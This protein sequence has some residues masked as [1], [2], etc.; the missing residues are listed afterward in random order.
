M[1]ITRRAFLGAAGG[2]TFGAMA[3]GGRSNTVEVVDRAATLPGLRRPMR[4]LFFSDQHLP[5][6]FV[7]FRA[8]RHVAA[9]FRPHLVLVGGDTVDRA[10]NERLVDGFAEIEADLGK[11][12]ILGNW[13]YEGHCDLELLQR[14]YA[15]AGVRLLVNETALWSSREHGQMRLVGLDDSRRGR[16]RPGLVEP[17]QTGGELATIVLAHCPSQFDQLPPV[18][19]LC[20]SG[21]THGGQITP[22]GL[23]LAP[24]LSGRY[25]SGWYRAG[26]QRQL[27]VTRGLGNSSVPFRIG[28]R[29]EIVRL[30]LSPA[31]GA[32]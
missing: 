5:R 22:L 6:C 13:E 8:L 32:A 23:V 25:V 3:Y 15:L 19:A 11:F 16:P 26:D 18:A 12:A 17:P 1:K 10:G 31:V 27:Y 20:L 14:R 28:A 30:T 21:H 9:A 7:T 24:S 29:P 4:V 2:G